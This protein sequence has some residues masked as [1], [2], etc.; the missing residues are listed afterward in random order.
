M[1]VHVAVGMTGPLTPFRQGFSEALELEGYALE[2]VELHLRLLA[3]LSRWLEE[4]GWGTSELSSDVIEEFFAARRSRHVLLKTPRSL[5]PLLR[6]LGSLGVLSSEP[7]GEVPPSAVDRLI[8]SYR[9][10]LVGER[11]LA[12]GS[13]EL[14]VTQVRRLA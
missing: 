9:R 11:G 12:A 6:Y 10:Y 14:Y 5:A 4:H 3:H 1:V 7:P 8:E 2:S 13:V